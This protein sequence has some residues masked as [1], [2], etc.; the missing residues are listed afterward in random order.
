MKKLLFR[1]LLLE[2][3]YFFLIALT[4]SS[5]I[6]WVFQSVNYLDIMIEDGRDYMVY[7]KYS[8]LNFP[9]I[10][11]KLLPFVLFF[12]LFYVT[13]R[14]ETNNELIMFWNF[15]VHKIELIN[16]M[17]RI[18][19]ALM[20]IQI[21][22]L[23]IVVPKSQDLAKS[24]I[25]SSKINFFENFI[26]QQ[27]FNDTIKGVT[28]FTEKKD[29]DGN[30]YNL[31][32]KRETD[33]D[34]FQLTYAKKGIFKEFKNVPVLVLYDGETITNKNNEL[35][36]FSF[37]KYDFPLNKIETNTVTYK[38]TQELSSL[39]IF[40][41]I[42]NLINTNFQN[43]YNKIENCR[44]DNLESIFKEIYKRLIIPLYIPLLVLV[45]YFLIYYSK[46]NLKYNLFKLI[47]FFSGLAI[48]IF[49]ETTIRLIS[50]N[51]LI[52]L[53]ISLLPIIF[54]V[55][56]YLKNLVTFNYKIKSK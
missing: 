2:Y 50:N 33:N 19:L 40:T 9:K 44:I 13:I 26:K 12:T 16:F 11:S 5:V 32:L 55:F 7:V 29:K 24:F 15:G 46:E 53:Y 14:F 45:N 20:L 3:L 34:N 37:S 17:I 42:K 8:L 10:L 49:S 25:R 35:T 27:K 31:Y 38:K 56:I 18:S 4:S 28:I 21:F 52:N 1:K 43:D 6:I 39:K 41:C 23:T 51:I 30:L 22:F 36:N 48:I 54:F 47:T